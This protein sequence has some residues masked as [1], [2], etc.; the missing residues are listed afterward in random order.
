MS[1]NWTFKH[2]AGFVAAKKAGKFVSMSKNEYGLYEMKKNDT[3]QTNYEYIE[4]LPLNG[5]I[6]Y[7]LVVL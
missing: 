6:W 5:F 7:D 2:A 1:I 4:A 3:G